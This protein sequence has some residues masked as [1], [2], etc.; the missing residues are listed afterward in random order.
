MSELLE[1]S[2]PHDALGT[3][4]VM[5][6]AGHRGV[7][8]ITIAVALLAVSVSTADER[9][10]KREATV[11]YVITEPEL[12]VR[13]MRFADRYAGFVTQAIDDVER[14]QSTP[15]ARRE[16]NAPLVHSI[17]AAY[18]KAADARPQVAL[19]DMVVMTT[20]GRMVF[21]EHWRPRFGASADPVVTALGNLERD[22]WNMASG[23]LTAEQQT[24]LRE[25][26]VS[27][28]K[29]HPELTNF[30]QTAYNDLPSTG[31]SSA[32]RRRAGGGMFRSVRRMTDQVEQTRMLA[33]RAMYLSTRLP[34]KSGFIADVW[35]SQIAAN[36]AVGGLL[37]DANAFAGASE[38]L[39]SVAEQLP[40]QL[41]E[42]RNETIRQLAREIALQREQALNQLLDGIALERERTIEQFVAEEQRLKGLI[43]EL[44]QTLVAGNELALSVGVLV[45]ALKPGPPDNTTPAAHREPA[46]PFDIDDY[47][48]ALVEAG[49]TIRDLNSLLG[50]TQQLLDSHGASELLPQLA[51]AIDKAGGESRAI[52]D[53]LFLRSLLLIVIA[54]TGYVIARL[55]HEWLALRLVRRSQ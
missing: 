3:E 12:Q 52:A 33:E 53:H 11:E 49:A 37:D 54:L 1:L 6:Q 41:A 45:E 25:R 24:E 10:N 21:E 18:I 13:L 39:A 51:T 22:I 30:S 55:V 40:V 42:E 44:H 31:E 9:R 19:L 29:E 32:L 7:V 50:S 35:L 26:V 34:L 27:F 8:T 17:A 38:R 48:H 2:S 14:L 16:F 47:R 5:S 46:K 4:A 43:T 23:I 36:P 28:R 15:E 20:L